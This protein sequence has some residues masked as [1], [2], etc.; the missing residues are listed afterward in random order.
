M[1]DGGCSVLPST[2]MFVVEFASTAMAS[3]SAGHPPTSAFAAT[4]TARAS[5]TAMAAAPSPGLPAGPA[6][7]VLFRT[8][9]PAASPTEMAGPRNQVLMV[10]CST[11][12]LVAPR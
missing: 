7:I 1:A 6:T 10:L 12:M 8:A 2:V 5:L 4:A 3:A 9:A 11:V